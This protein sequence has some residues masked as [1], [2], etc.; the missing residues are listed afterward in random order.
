[1]LLEYDDRM[2]DKRHEKVRMTATV[3]ADA[4]ARAAVAAGQAAS[5]SAWVNQAMR[6]RAEHESRLAAGRRFIAEYEAEHGVITEEDMQEAERWARERTI[7]VTD[8]DIE[9]AQREARERS[10][11]WEGSASPF[12][13]IPVT[14]VLDAGA[15]VAVERGEKAVTVM[16]KREILAGR[17]PVTHGGVIGQVWRSG[18]GRQASLAVLLS[19]VWVVPLDDALGR[20]AGVLLGRDGG[21]DVIDAALVLL[22]VDGDQIL[23]SDPDDLRRLAAASGVRVD[24]V[25]V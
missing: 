10:I 14:L 12:A 22:A 6:Q 24:L 23:T 1:M 11:A 4:A 2:Q 17:A 8:E 3:D 25:A 9:E 7:T 13:P 16:V 15:L 21:S 20:R 19:S 5:V 18:S